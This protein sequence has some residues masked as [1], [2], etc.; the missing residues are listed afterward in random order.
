[1]TD[2]SHSPTRGRRGATSSGAWAGFGAG[3]AG[4]AAAVVIRML[5]GIP[6][7]AER[8]A[9][10]LTIFIPV[11]LFDAL[12][13][14]FGTLAKPLLVV[15]VGIGVL[16]AGAV[17]GWAAARSGSRARTIAAAAVLAALLGVG[18]PLALDSAPTAIAGI[19]AALL[20][21][22]I[23][24]NAHDPA[25]EPNPEADASR[26][27]LLQWAA[28]A[29]VLL[30]AGGL[31]WRLISS[32]GRVIAGML[33][34]T[35]TPNADFYVIS[36]NLIDPSVDAASWRLRVGGLVERPLEL[37]LDELKALGEVE[38]LQ[39]LECISN[40][41]GG[42]LIS[43][44]RWRG[45]PLRA[46]VERMGPRPSVVE[47]KLSAEDGYSESI[48]LSMAADSRVLLVFEMNGEPLP[49]RHGFPMRLLLPG[50]YGMKGPKWLSGIEAVDTPYAGYWEQRGWTKEATIKT[51]S[52]LDAPGSAAPLDRRSP[53]QLAG[54]AFAGDRGIRAVE[55]QLGE[56]A[57]WTAAELD[58]PVGESPAG[59][60][61][62]WRLGWSPARAGTYRVQ[63]RAIDG[64][65]A[66]QSAQVAGTL[67]DGASGY[68]G[69]SYTVS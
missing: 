34:P 48:P 11:G 60:W 35:I 51:M 6:T 15:V 57:A 59:V 20:F 28:V 53:I 27:H 17:I 1:M 68:D 30:L 5:T 26:R 65:G 52:R 40:E 7:V 66:S 50:T 24:A 41:V 19:P 39:T 37:T 16:G 64:S 21:V 10:V 29:G 36:K 42:H 56:G 46:V 54:I 2:R 58:P 18:L 23:F 67:P 31:F 12:L 22:V 44:A 38:Q 47:L 43:T 8:I 13:G 4:L 49:E 9:E 45:V 61:R 69:T 25:A 63:V 3:A 14:L 55:V 33:P 32:G 62:F